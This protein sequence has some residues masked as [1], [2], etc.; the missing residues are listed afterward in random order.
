M[1][2]LLKN[3][4]NEHYI[5]RLCSEL[6]K[7]SPSFDADTFT[8]KIF[9]ENWT[10]RELKERMRH[11]STT[12]AA[13]LPKEY[14][15][16]VE[17]LKQCFLHMNKEFSLENIIFQDFVEVYGLNDFQTSMY[18]LECF[19]I[20]S[21]SEYAIRKF[22]LK[23]Q[24]QTMKQLRLW[25]KS[26]NEHL[27]RLACEGCRPRLPWGI[28]LENFQKDPTEVLEIL[29]ILKDDTS[30]YVK[31]SLANNLN[32]ISKDNPE[33]VIEILKRWRKEEPKREWIL[34]HGCR[35]LLKKGDKETLG[36]F[37]F[38]LPKHIELHNFIMQES[39]KMGADLNFSFTLET[40][41]TLGLLR[42]EYAI[43]FLR[44]NTQSNKKVFH[45]AQGEYNAQ[46]KNFSKSYSFKPI[47]T[48]K[49]YEGTHT[50]FILVNGVS[51]AKKEF[52]L[53]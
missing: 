34:K 45:I 51:L 31:K 43:E 38:S 39:V 12:L 11:I 30:L 53:N 19:T 5:E 33:I 10:P 48:R 8:L 4:Y 36:I 28:A 29:E 26:E 49:Y 17:I 27:R 14:L 35:T 25:A 1:A 24:T 15:N 2:E 21:T 52:I 3:L 42:V 46:K 6:L 40:D 9:D 47:T 18:A 7:V 32:D 37:G 41:G 20:N 16:A 23:Y 13:F 50:I 22:I 44:K